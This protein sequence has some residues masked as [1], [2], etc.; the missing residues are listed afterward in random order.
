MTAS[1]VLSFLERYGVSVHV[2]PVA[3]WQRRKNRVI[4]AWRRPDG[5]EGAIGG[6]SVSDAV[7]KAAA[8]QAHQTFPANSV[9]EVIH[10]SF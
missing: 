4:V 2:Q 6:Y 7:A 3:A 8:R 9:S 10:D 5:T 1:E